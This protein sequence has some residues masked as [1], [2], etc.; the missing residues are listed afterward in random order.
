MTKVKVLIA[1][2]CTSVV[3]LLLLYSSDTSG[4]RVKL[5]GMVPSTPP[6]AQARFHM[7]P[8]GMY[9]SLPS[10]RQCAHRVRRSSWEPR[11]ENYVPNHTIVNRHAVRRAFASRARSGQETYDPRWDS[12]LLP[13]VD[14]QFTGTTD[15]IIQWAACKWGLNDN[16]LRGVLILES[17]WYQYETYPSGRCVSNWGCGDFFTNEPDHPRS[18][19][20]DTLAAYGHDYQNDFGKAQ[21]PK[22]FSIAGVM[23]WSSPTWGFLWRGLQNGTF[24]FARDSTAYALDYLASQLRGCYEGWK[25]WLHDRPG[26]IWGCVGA[27]Y[28]GNWRSPNADRY[29]ARVKELIRVHEW[30]RPGFK[31]IRPT[32]TLL[33][34]CPAGIF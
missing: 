17:T 13:R 8:P 20:C 24:P 21:C 16:V 10:D 11:P 23:S 25:F 5:H 34:G 27:W 26:D 18:V 14:G 30:L 4:E 31:K 22:T 1:G 2:I 19:Y 32:C 29:I 9:G 15:E 33:Y 3:C 28:A 12:W 7:S 6:P